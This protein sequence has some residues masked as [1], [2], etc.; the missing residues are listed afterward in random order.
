MRERQKTNVRASARTTVG[1]A[2]TIVWRLVRPFV[3]AI[4]AVALLVVTGLMWFENALIFFPM[5]YPSGDWT[6]PGLSPEDAW[7]CAPDGTRLHGWYVPHDDPLAVVLFC[8]GNA[9]NVTHRVE[10]MREMHSRVGASILVFDYRG[11]GRSQ[12]SPSEPGVLADARA[13]RTWLARRAGIAERQIVLMGESIGGA[14]AIDLAAQ[15]G[16]RALILEST[17]TSLGDVAA[18]HFPWLPVRLLLRSRFDSLDK[19]SAFHGPLLQSHGDGDTIV[20]YDLGRRLFDAA[21]EPKQFLTL[22]GADHNDL[23][24]RAYY[25]EVRKFLQALPPDRR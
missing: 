17:F 23:P 1:G 2:A 15:D 8:H 25:D 7:F 10:K 9:G 13:A 22:R 5:T 16:A 21:H 3:I 20:P 4:I 6:P 18:Y 19:I 12:G 24:G 11:F 14:V